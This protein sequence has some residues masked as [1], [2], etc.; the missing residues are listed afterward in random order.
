MFSLDFVKRPG[1]GTLV[2]LVI[3]MGIAV[4]RPSRAAE[5]LPIFEERIP[6]TSV[7]C[8]LVDRQRELRDSLA[9]RP[10]VIFLSDVKHGTDNP[11]GELLAM[12]QDE[13]FYWFTWAG[14]LVGPATPEQRALVHSRSPLRLE[15]CFNDSEGKI[16]GTL[17]MKSLP[18]LLLVNENGYIV[19]KVENYSAGKSHEVIG[20]IDE[21]ARSSSLKGRP[22]R[23][24]RLPEMGSGRLTTLLDVAGK[25]YIFLIF[26]RTKS[27]RCLNELQMLQHIRDK[28]RDEATLVAVFQ[29]RSPMEDIR[30]YLDTYGIKPDFVLHDPRLRQAKSYSF[31][32]V[33]VLLVGGPDGKV[34]FSQKGYE[35]ERS[36]YLASD[37]DRI[38]AD[39]KEHVTD[40][41]LLE[42]RR[43]YTEVLQ[44]L[45]VGRTEAALS[46]LESILELKP[47]LTTVHRLI[48]D[49]QLDL[50]K[51]REAARHYGKYISAN[52]HAYDLPQV[53][54]ILRSLSGEQPR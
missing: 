49:S 25:D 52:P 42:A 54:D 11:L 33:P 44:H 34:L 20:N 51:Q 48:A 8:S 53:R 7:Y 50:G 19:R 31:N 47:E 10:A 24:F 43:L 13:Y 45:E 14:L 22:L 5:E 9:G 29:D 32:S 38:F 40:T 15:H 27:A 35:P 3:L 30:T 28:Y 12:I 41:S 16:W 1:Y 26:L 46:L 18:A 2:L 6:D 4:S 36:W 37:L 17:G 21:L 23:D 39:K